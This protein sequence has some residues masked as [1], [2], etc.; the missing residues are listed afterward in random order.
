MGTAPR[1]R[2]AGRG[3]HRA[4]GPRGNS[5]ACAGSSLPA[6]SRFQPTREQ[7]RVRGEQDRA[8]DNRGTAPRAR[9]AGRRLS[10]FSPSVGNSP[11]C[12]GS[13]DSQV[14]LSYAP[15][16]QP[17]VRGEQLAA[18]HAPRALPGT[19]PRA[20]G[21]AGQ[22]GHVGEGD[23]NSPACAGSRTSRRLVFRKSREQPRVR[24]E[25]DTIS[26]VTPTA[27]GTAP[28]ARGAGPGQGAHRPA[29]GNS[30]AC[31]G[32]SRGWRGGRRTY[33]EQPRVRGE[34]DAEARSSSDW[35]GTAP[36]ARGA[37]D[38][39][40]DD[41]GRHGNSPACAG[42]RGTT[43]GPSGWTGEQPRVRGEQPGALLLVV[44]VDGT[45]PRARGA[46]LVGGDRPVPVGNSPACAGSRVADSVA[47]TSA[48]EQ[49]RVRGEQCRAVSMAAMPQG[50]APRARGAA[51]GAV[52]GEAL[53]GN[54]PACAG[55]R[56]ARAG[57]T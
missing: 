4:H 26:P 45:A 24:G 38:D 49:P 51:S 3:G 40:A 6:M 2:G 10:W 7:P 13:R 43:P 36:R 1:A 23:G 28:R 12:A 35:W 56:A 8:E 57:R 55:S 9:G 29:A 47:A 44:P 52:H 42:S 21:A 32:S 37:V 14:R 17:R 20:R 31:A 41:R 48:R 50:T 30:P 22:L 39:R 53:H 15:R 27:R 34:Q 5:P 19:A 18:V 11:A 54:S 25:Q 46:G 33:R 16:E